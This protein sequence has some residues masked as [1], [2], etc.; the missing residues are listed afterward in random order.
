MMSVITPMPKVRANE[1]LY[2]DVF[3][4]RGISHVYDAGKWSRYDPDGRLYQ[5]FAH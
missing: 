4:P 5:S 1:Q 2:V 3:I